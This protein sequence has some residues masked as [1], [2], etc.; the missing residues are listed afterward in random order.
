M[1]INRE[2]DIEAKTPVEKDLKHRKDVIREELESL[3]KEN[4]KI[5]DWNV[6]EA[7]GQKA[8]EILINILEEKLKEIKDNVAKGKYEYL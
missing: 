8:S 3:F 4:I 1:K 6:P 2:D 7:D 5:V